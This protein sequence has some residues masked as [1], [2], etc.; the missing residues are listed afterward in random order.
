MKTFAIVVMSV[1]MSASVAAQ[2]TYTRPRVIDGDQW[3][4]P[5]TPLGTRDYSQRGYGRDPQGV[6]RPEG[7][8]PYTL[9]YSAPA[10]RFE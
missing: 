3:I 2:T 7:N 5:Q 4:T 6:W 10:W 8:L 9:D 1:L